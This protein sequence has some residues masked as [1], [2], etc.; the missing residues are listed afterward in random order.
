MNIGLASV[1]VAALV[2]AGCNSDGLK[3]ARPGFPETQVTSSGDGGPEARA[4]PTEAVVPGSPRTCQ[5][6][7]KTAQDCAIPKNPLGDQN[8]YACTQGLCQWKGCTS[9]AECQAAAKTD[10]VV[11]EKAPGAPIS[12]CVP[13]CTAGADC[14]NSQIPLSGPDH[15]TCTANRCQW[16]GCASTAECRTALK[17]DKL[18]CEKA[19]GAPFADCEPVCTTAA[20]CAAPGEAM[21]DASHFAC[22]A[23]RCQWLGCK[24]DDECRA[25]L[26]GAKYVCR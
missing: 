13:T 25:A 4:T 24:S 26:R 14:G 20:D 10:K 7:C 16:K 19:A 6:A 11:C 3:K 15:F 1:F 8:H 21:T 9:T 23:G 18:V 22:T 2:A 5:T 17:N 12:D